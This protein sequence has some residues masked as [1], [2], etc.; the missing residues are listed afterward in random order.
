MNR[1]H[2]IT[3]SVI[4]LC[5]VAINGCS[6]EPSSG[7]IEK[8][9]RAAVDQENQQAK[10][11]FGEKIATGDMLTKVHEAR[12]VSCAAAQGFPGFNCDV[13]LD[14][15]VPLVGRQKAVKQL[16]FVKASDGWQVTK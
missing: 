12:K 14:V 15:S 8:A 7:D 4:A 10:K 9:I 13:E 16:R 2:L 3:V 1:N 5:M 11:M 6:S